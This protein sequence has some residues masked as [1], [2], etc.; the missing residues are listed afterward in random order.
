MDIIQTKAFLVCVSVLML[1]PASSIA[2]SGQSGIPANNSPLKLLPPASQISSPSTPANQMPPPPPIANIQVFMTDQ[3][4]LSQEFPAPP[5]DSTLYQGNAGTSGLSVSND[6]PPAPP[7]SMDSPASVLNVQNAAEQKPSAPPPPD[8]S[9]SVRIAQSQASEKPPV[10][11]QGGNGNPS[12]GVAELGSGVSGVVTELEVSVAP[13]QIVSSNGEEGQS[14]P[15]KAIN[16]EKISKAPVMQIPSNSN[17]NSNGKSVVP[18]IVIK[19][20]TPK[21]P[22]PFFPED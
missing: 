13:E 9:Q 4:S 6:S 7:F 22:S 8:M 11:P 15:S 12:L 20:K 17:G 2:A 21:N 10:P 3:N 1:A 16:K 19:L 18:Q 5:T 14:S